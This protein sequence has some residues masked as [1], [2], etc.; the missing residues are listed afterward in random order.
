MMIAQRNRGRI[1][2][3]YTPIID[4]QIRSLQNQY[5]KFHVSYFELTSNSCFAICKIERNDSGEFLNETLR[6]KA[7]SKQEALNNLYDLVKARINELGAPLDWNNIDPVRMVVNSHIQFLKEVNSKWDCLDLKDTD[8]NI[9]VSQI[10]DI[11]SK[12]TVSVCHNLTDFNEH[13][14][15]RLV[16]C[17]DPAF[18][19][20]GNAKKIDAMTDLFAYV[21]NPSDLVLL[22]HEAHLAKIE[23]V[24]STP[25]KL[26]QRIDRVSLD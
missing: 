12:Y 16:S 3:E 13:D 23:S 20:V 11:V 1:V 24:T 26:D 6:S 5:Y 14:L 8:I 7:N 18:Y 15:V 4:E 17:D 10:V 25:E 22:A 19:S 2:N 9:V 21:K